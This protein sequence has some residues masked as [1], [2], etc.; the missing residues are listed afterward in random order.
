MS[1]INNNSIKKYI[2]IIFFILFITVP[3]AITLGTTNN[4]KDYDKQLKEIKSMTQVKA[5]ILDMLKF[6][7]KC[8]VGSCWNVSSTSICDYI[9]LVD[10]KVSGDIMQQMTGFPKTLKMSKSELELMK[11]L[12]SYCKPTNYQY[13]NYDH[14][15]H[16]IFTA[17][18]EE[19]EKL[20]K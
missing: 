16:V 13:W 2:F 12:F 15:L 8:E 1:F 4:N 11:K 17:K 6:R 3:V 20:L 10:V 18:I 14:A 7:E 9:A 5:E 19:V